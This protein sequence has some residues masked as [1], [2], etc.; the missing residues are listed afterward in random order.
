MK[1]WR[2]P[3]I[4]IAIF[5]LLA[6]V[7][8][9]AAEKYEMVRQGSTGE[10]V[11]RVQLRL[12]ELDYLRFKPTGS[13]KGMTVAA[14]IAFQQLQV[15]DDGSYVAADGEA[16]E[17]TQSILFSSRARRAPIAAEVEIPIGPALKGSP[18]VEGTLVSWDNVKSKL[19]TN[20]TYK[21][22][23]YN[24]GKSLR[25]LYL[26]GENHAEAE[27]ATPEDTEIFL[28]IFGGEYNFSKRPV[29]LQLDANTPVAASMFGYPHGTD[30][31]GGNDMTGH[32]CIFFDGSRSHVGR[33][34]DVE[35]QKQIYIAAGM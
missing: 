14:T 18:T 11:Q 2:I 28:E 8:A 7:N 33:V 25:L 24:T 3:C 19:I 26:G 5:T 34:T 15:T 32:V 16:G 35:H 17:Q 21:V 9:M 10:A 12:R 31:K 4:L 22:Y 23:D 30:A 1:T 13:F 27:C 6:C 20:T 29:V